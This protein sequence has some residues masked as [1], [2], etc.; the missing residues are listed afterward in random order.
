MAKEH[1]VSQRA[2]QLHDNPINLVLLSA[3][4][5]LAE[6]LLDKMKYR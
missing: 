6:L 4:G 3:R 1:T 2:P 5:F